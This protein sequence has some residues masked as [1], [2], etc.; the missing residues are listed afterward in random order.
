MSA[1]EH[2]NFVRAGNEVGVVDLAN[3]RPRL[4]RGGLAPASV[5]LGVV[6]GDGR[7]SYLLDELFD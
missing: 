5:F 7:P 2:R 3:W 6:F 1:S 4:G